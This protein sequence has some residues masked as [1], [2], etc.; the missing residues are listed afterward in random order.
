MPTIQCLKKY[1][2]CEMNETEY[3]N[4]IRMEAVCFYCFDTM[5]KRNLSALS[6][7]A[8]NMPIIRLLTRDDNRA[9]S[10]LT[11]RC[12]HAFWPFFE[13]DMRC[14]WL[15]TSLQSRFISLIF[16]RGQITFINTKKEPILCFLLQKYSFLA[17]SGLQSEWN[18]PVPGV[19]DV[20]AEVA[21]CMYFFCK[22][23]IDNI[24][25]LR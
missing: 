15:I 11:N 9:D 12:Q 23:L 2:F 17:S 5:L 24:G 1:N 7:K 22:S 14:K 19:R 18:M 6:T 25:K 13:A 4:K 21:G 16:K 8:R 10:V 20:L 3:R